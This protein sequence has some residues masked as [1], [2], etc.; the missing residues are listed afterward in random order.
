MLSYRKAQPVVESICKKHGVPYI[1]HNVFYRLW[2]LVEI[3]VGS[4]SMRKYPVAFEH[5]P[6][7]GFEGVG[8]ESNPDLRITPHLPPK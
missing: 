2:K 1:K 8:Y 3:M 7:C 6:D 4:A 5:K